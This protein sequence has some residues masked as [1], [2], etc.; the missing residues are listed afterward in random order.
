MRQLCDRYETGDRA[1]RLYLEKRYGKKII[2]TAIEESKSHAWMESNTK[3]CPSC[4][5]SIEVKPRSH[6]IK[7]LKALQSLQEK[8]SLPFL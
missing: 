7:L 4:D 5:A 3:P 1:E 6:T 8:R 2:T